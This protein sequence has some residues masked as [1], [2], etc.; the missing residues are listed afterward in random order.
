MNLQILCMANHILLSSLS[1]NDQ[2]IYCLVKSSLVELTLAL[3]ITMD[4]LVLDLFCSNSCCRSIIS[5]RTFYLYCQIWMA[6]SCDYFQYYSIS[7]SCLLSSEFR[8]RHRDR[9]MSARDW[10]DAE[11]PL[12]NVLL[13]QG[14]TSS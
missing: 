7:Q 10:G 14:R 11:G 1:V 13:A 9:T 5:C 6:V 3:H 4:N 8:S 12:L 2:F